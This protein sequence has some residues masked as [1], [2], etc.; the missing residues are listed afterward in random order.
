MSGFVEDRDILPP[1]SPEGVRHC[2]TKKSFDTFSQVVHMHTHAVQN[3]RYVGAGKLRVFQ[4][5]LGDAGDDA[6]L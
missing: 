4:L 1:N 5:A 3:T 6:V 2:P